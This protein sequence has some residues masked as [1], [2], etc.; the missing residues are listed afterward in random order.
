MGAHRSWESVGVPWTQCLL[1][2]MIHIELVVIQ[3]NFTLKFCKTQYSLTYS[4]KSIQ[5]RINIALGTAR[6]QK[7]WNPTG[8]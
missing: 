7:I 8:L 2:D 4:R 1:F 3:S 6:V 5:H